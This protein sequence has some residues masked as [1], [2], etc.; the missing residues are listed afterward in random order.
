MTQPPQ[1]RATIP[2]QASPEHHKVEMFETW[3]RTKGEAQARIL[4]LQEIYKI[5]LKTT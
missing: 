4:H 2:A 1:D 3:V 5:K